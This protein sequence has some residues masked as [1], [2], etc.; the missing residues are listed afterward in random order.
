MF[1][2]LAP[3]LALTSLPLSRYLSKSDP[4]SLVSYAGAS[5]QFF[6]IALSI[7]LITLAELAELLLSTDR[8]VKGKGFEI[9]ISVQFL[10]G[11]LLSFSVAGLYF[12]SVI[13]DASNSPQFEQRDFII[14]LVVTILATVTGLAARWQL[15]SVK[16]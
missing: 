14:F 15:E 10:V 16:S 9:G 7:T 13:I 2:F 11:I 8:E 12:N 6:F 3:L 5:S 4:W 1:W